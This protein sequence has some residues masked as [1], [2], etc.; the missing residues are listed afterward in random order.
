[1]TVIIAIAAIF[2]TFV[3]INDNVLH[4]EGV[5]TTRDVLKALGFGET[6]RR[7]RGRYPYISWTWVRGTASLLLR[8]TTP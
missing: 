5:P 1:M 6:S 3:L 7:S 2:M 4:I 8:P